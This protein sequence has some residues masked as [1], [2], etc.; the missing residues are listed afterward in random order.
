[1][2]GVF[3][4]GF[5]DALMEHDVHF[6][7]VIGV[8]AGAC[9]GLS[10]GSWQRGRA[11]YASIEILKEYDYIS[12]K[13]LIRTGCIFD[14][15]LLY[16]RL[17]RELYP[18]DYDNY[19]RQKNFKFE[20]VVTNCLTGRA[21]YLS[22]HAGNSQRLLDICHASSSL[23]YVSKI[24]Y[25]DDIPYLDGGIVDSVPVQRAFDQG[26]DELV[27][28]MTRNRGFRKTGKDYKQP[29]FI[30]KK[31]PRLRVALSHRNKLYNE[32]MELVERLEDEGK[33]TVIWPER[34]MEV[35]RL[36]K[37]IDK[38]EALYQEGFALGERYCATLKQQA[39]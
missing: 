24:I 17:P 12:I 23:P 5:L 26:C 11:H 32:Q 7:Y 27:V 21:D 38:L 18:Y 14:P 10:Y 34:P 29:R 39:P 22:E 36:E 35:D 20:Q 33:I 4:V 1:M 15:D 25:V 28:V 16:D 31:Y 2:R 19:F 9:H 37:N 6:P 30:Y 13:H 3:T 8:S